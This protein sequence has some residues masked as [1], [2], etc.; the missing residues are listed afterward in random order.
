MSA[1]D[2]RPPIAPGERAPGFTLPAVN[3][4]GVI[5]LE[6]YRGRT[7]VLIGLFRGLH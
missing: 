1:A 3:R 6:D 7:A 2:A 5:S 4:D